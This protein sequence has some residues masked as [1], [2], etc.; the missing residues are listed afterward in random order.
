MNIIR[1]RRIRPTYYTEDRWER[2]RLAE[3]EQ[4]RC[5]ICMM[6]RPSSV[7]QTEDGNR[8]CPDCL[9]VRSEEV[10]ARIA[11]ADAQRIAQRQTRPQISQVPLRSAA[12]PHIL[13]MENAGG[14]RITQSNPLVIVRSGSAVT[15][16]ITGGG[17]A[18]TDTFTYSTGIT[19]DSAP[20]LTGTTV[21]T[22]S[23]VA[24]GAATPGNNHL[25]FNDHTYRGILRIA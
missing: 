23:L 13:K 17:F 5:G 11:E 10:K 3:V 25:T 4:E 1:Q 2:Q 22:L 7:M 16:T 9:A 12:V 14:T 19:D 15:L 18:S 20:S 24:S 8:R 21:W 6:L